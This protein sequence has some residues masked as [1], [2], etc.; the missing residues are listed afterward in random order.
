MRL[1]CRQKGKPQRSAC[2]LVGVMVFTL[3]TLAALTGPLQAR[4]TTTIA[5][6]IFHS[7]GIRLTC[8]PGG[9]AG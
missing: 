6:G 8:P 5:K 7:L 1:P 3:L 4:Q 2:R 9:L